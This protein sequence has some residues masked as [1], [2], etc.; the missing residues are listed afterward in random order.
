[1]GSLLLDAYNIA[2]PQG[3]GVATYGRTLA[4]IAGSLG[5]DVNL[6][7]QSRS[8]HSKIPLL[9]EVMLAEGE[10][11]KARSLLSNLMPG[12]I[13]QAAGGVLTSRRACAVPL[14]G[15][16]IMPAGL[17]LGDARFWSAP[18]LYRYANG[19]FAATGRVSSVR[20][21]QADLAHW[22]YPLPVKLKNAAN[23]Y[24]LHDL[25]PLRLPHTT[26][27][28]KKQYY[29]LCRKIAAE[30]DHI[31]TVS[32]CSR[33]DII[34]ILG[35]DEDRVTNLYQSTDIA[36][37]LEGVDR[38]QI[39]REVEGLLGVAERGYYLFFGAVEPKK[40]LS[41]LVEAYL[42]SRSPYPLV[43]VGAPGWGSEREVKL[44]KQMTQL[45]QAN[46]IKWLGYLPRQ[47]LAATIACARA[48]MFPSLY[49]GF[50]LPVLEA[51]SLG[52]P[53]VTS[54]VSSMPEVAGDAA[55]LVDP[56]DVRAISCAIQQLDRPD[57][58]IAQ[59]GEAGLKQSLQFSVPAYQERL[60]V[61]YD[62]F[63]SLSGSAVAPISRLPLEK[64]VP[65][66]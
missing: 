55:L 58:T 62:K 12:A 34:R 48:V 39:V 42:A 25:V 31:V 53:V 54:N 36:A 41:R 43:I 24:T 16:V 20:G 63:A 65:S 13:M 7:F 57:T 56:Y 37:L 38:A 30:A 14:S 28:Q 64:K 19:A 51:M 66:A 1:M 21:P 29:K 32:E 45:D 5:H 46:R 33:R 47:M 60:R 26:A 6:L 3:T 35:A 18:Q 22:T 52:T 23:I 49:E 50:G 8:G 44:L 17:Q 9:N 15:E 4:T 2:L 40:N 27:D 61:F 10:P 11:S 59:L